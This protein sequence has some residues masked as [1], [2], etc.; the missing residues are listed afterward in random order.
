MVLEDTCSGSMAIGSGLREHASRPN[1][2]GMENSHVRLSI[3]AE[4]CAY[5]L[6]WKGHR[7]DPSRR[8]YLCTSH[9]EIKAVLADRGCA[10][11]VNSIP[12]TSSELLES[13]SK[14]LERMRLTTMK[15]PS[16]WK[17]NQLLLHIANSDAFVYTQNITQ[18]QP[19]HSP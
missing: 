16:I 10:Q 13:Y 12:T 2:S 15:A 1:F 5:K 7:D 9:D 14:A 6:G 8:L 19:D 4:Q 17:T 11:E 18:P 3:A